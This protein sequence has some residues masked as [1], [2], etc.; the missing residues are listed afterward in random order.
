M[1]SILNTNP[2]EAPVRDAICKI[3]GFFV[4]PESTQAQSKLKEMFG[5]IWIVHIENTP[6]FRAEEG[7]QMFFQNR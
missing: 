4:A 5:S 6:F 7:Y 3:V 1:I 2:T